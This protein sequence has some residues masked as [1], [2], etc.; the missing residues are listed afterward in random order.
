[1]L[2]ADQRKVDRVIVGR[3]HRLPLSIVATGAVALQ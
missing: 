3:A 1:M 2:M